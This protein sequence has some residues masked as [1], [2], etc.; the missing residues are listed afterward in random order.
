MAVQSE[1]WDA[2]MIEIFGA[3]NLEDDHLTEE[4][5]EVIQPGVPCNP[6]RRLATHSSFVIWLQDQ[7]LARC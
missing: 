5:N 1:E 6:R 4:E 7:C 2:L 3:E